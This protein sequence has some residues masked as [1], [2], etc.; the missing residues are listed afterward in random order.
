MKLR[1]FVGCCS[2]CESKLPLAVDAVETIDG[3][4]LPKQLFSGF[5]SLLTGLGPAYAPKDD[6]ITELRFLKSVP[7]ELELERR[8]ASG[9]DKDDGGGAC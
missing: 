9:D 4:R 5:P 1:A 8:R 3:D 7:N 2:S 6:D